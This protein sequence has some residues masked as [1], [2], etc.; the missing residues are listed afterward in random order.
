MEAAEGLHAFGRALGKLKEAL[1]E[2]P[3]ELTR[4]A[5]SKRFE[6][7]FEL[8]W[9]AVQRCLREEG[10]QCRSPR[11]CLREAFTFG[12][13]ADDPRWITMIE[14]RNLTSHTYDETTAQ[15]VFAGL[16]EYVPLL[17]QL[18]QSLTRLIASRERSP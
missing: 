9:K 11:G 14:D 5:A 1:A 2:P 13:I 12:L 18:H 15:K 4:D 7:T 3:S 16:S 17:E 10:I 8:A 6:F